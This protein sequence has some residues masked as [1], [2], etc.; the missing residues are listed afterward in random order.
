MRRRRHVLQV[1]TFPFLAVL[2]CTMGSLI[3]LLLVIDK[4]AKAVARAKAAQQLAEQ[5]RATADEE[6][7]K[8]DAWEEQLRNLH[9]LLQQQLDEVRGQ[10]G[11]LHGRMS[12]AAAD[13]A[14]TQGK[15]Q[16]LRERLQAE[17]KRYAQIAEAIAAKKTEL[18]NAGKQD[19][20]TEGQRRQLTIDLALLEKTLEE[21]QAAK[22]LEK[23]TFSLVPYKGRRGDNRKPLYLECTANGWVFHPD[24]QLIE[25]TH[26]GVGKLHAE[27]ERR[28]RSAT[29]EPSAYLFL[30]VRPDG[31]TNYYRA[32]AAMLG[33]E[34]AYGYEFVDAAWVLDFSDHPEGPSQPWMN[35][36]PDK[37][38]IAASPSNPPARSQ[39]EFGKEANAGN[40]AHATKPLPWILRQAL[41][42]S[43][44]IGPHGDQPRGSGTGAGGDG[45]TPSFQA[46]HGS[47]SPDLGNGDGGGNMHGTVGQGPGAT[48]TGVREDPADSP[49]HAAV[50]S[51]RLES[52]D[53]LPEL[54]RERDDGS[55]SIPGGV[56]LGSP[57][58]TPGSGASARARPTPGSGS[59]AGTG[60]RAGDPTAPPAG[61]NPPSGDPSPAAA[62]TGGVRED[63]SATG[64]GTTTKPSA[65][66]GSGRVPYPGETP[67]ASVKLPDGAGVSRGD[68][69]SVRDGQRGNLDGP[70]SSRLVGKEKSDE[71]SAER[72]LPGLG[73][74]SL[75]AT[76]G[77]GKANSGSADKPKPFRLTGN[78]DWV[79]PLT[80]LPDGVVLPTGAKV[81]AASLAGKEGGDALRKAVQEL[82]ARK[83]AT[84]REGDPPYRPQIR[85]LVHPEG[86]RVYHLAYPTLESLQVQILRQNLES[87][88]SNQP[89][90][91]GRQP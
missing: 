38:F 28:L 67:D 23:Q 37:G 26:D 21:L 55:R 17:K 61:P 76:P 11:A 30:L 1:S 15:S 59:A 8:Q 41:E 56:G 85:F 20:A 32:Q 14:T 86:L 27:L 10:S 57:R 5:K 16:E 31:I 22:K 29:A 60:G 25:A 24:R 51:G 46:P 39:T 49:F 73:G 47:Q 64:T 12:A 80:C 69:T 90:A 79:L 19:A 6:K 42:A 62:G 53:G 75:P 81:T 48:R 52:R 91:G 78:R 18:A 50:S 40:E 65:P 63:S 54:P 89:G 2:L 83:Q 44:P 36:G 43:A 7:A 68:S 84:V 35:P 77:R 82:I 3:L 88:D 71:E 72:P 34:V 87:E 13:L 70:P 58:P 33:L 74:S 9:A 4:R 66:R 45:R